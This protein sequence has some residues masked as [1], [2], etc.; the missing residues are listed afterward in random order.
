MLSSARPPISSASDWSAPSNRRRRHRPGRTTSP[1]HWRPA[2]KRAEA[3]GVANAM[4]W[5]WMK[6][7][8]KKTICTRGTVTVGWFSHMFCQT[9]AFS[10]RRNRWEG[11]QQGHIKSCLHCIRHVW[12]YNLKPWKSFRQ[13]IQ[14][15]HSHCRRAHGSKSPWHIAPPLSHGK[16]IALCRL[17]GTPRS[18]EDIKK[19]KRL[20]WKEHLYKIIDTLVS[21]KGYK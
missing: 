11:S 3:K 14:P 20:R 21:R 10:L 8:W 15:E 17:Q 12:K 13:Q 9:H 19:S 6:R 7:G 4:P 1:R 16:V 5:E 2:S 18:E